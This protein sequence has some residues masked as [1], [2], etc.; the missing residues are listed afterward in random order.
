[1]DTTGTEYIKPLRAD[2]LVQYNSCN[3]L[4]C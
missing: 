1:M 4:S 2:F 3:H